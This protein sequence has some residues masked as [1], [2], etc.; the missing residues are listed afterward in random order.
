M[1]KD[2]K[3]FVKGFNWGIPEL[4]KEHFT[5]SSP[6]GDGAVT[7]S[8][9][10]NV[11]TQANQGKNEMTIEFA[12]DLPT[13]GVT[14]IRFHV[15]AEGT[16]KGTDDIQEAETNTV[17]GKLIHGVRSK[18]VGEDVSA[19]VSFSNI[20][21]HPRGRVEISLFK[22]FARLRGKSDT[23]K[24]KYTNITCMF[25]LPTG[26]SRVFFILSLEHPIKAG[27]QRHQHLVLDI[28]EEI[29]TEDDAF[30]INLTEEEIT[31]MNKSGVPKIQKHMHGKLHE[32]M[33]KL[34]KRLSAAKVM[35]P[36]RFKSA[37][38][39]LDDDDKEKKAIQ[40]SYKAVVG[41]LFPLEKSFFFLPKP[42]LY[43]KNDDIQKVK[44]AQMEN[45]RRNFD[46]SIL[47]SQAQAHSFTHIP[48]F[49]YDALI[50]WFKVKSIPVEGGKDE[51][52]ANQL[53]LDSSSDDDD[54]D[55][56]DSVD[57]G[58]EPNSEDDMPAKKK[59]KKD[60]EGKKKKDKKEKKSKKKSH[61][62]GSEKKKKKKSEKG[63][64]KKEKKR[65]REAE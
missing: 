1:A 40:C 20:A 45:G 13:E 3:Q 29:V 60:K 51:L 54:F 65:K 42:A 44:I 48:M 11:I 22:D 9:P 35:G 49:E 6:E 27:Q 8:F 18:L 12:S 43:I 31:E 30:E 59:K 64:K 16:T 39:K 57:P 19:I 46:I 37:D 36:S 4:D 50:N 15:P 55:D 56:D 32:I 34:L 58:E 63:E 24:L 38:T 7:F 10:F 26:D 2:A 47:T 61:K 62:D 23:W 33:A 28:K 41:Q 14:E 53:D 25:L 17:V 21:L 52:D 5:L